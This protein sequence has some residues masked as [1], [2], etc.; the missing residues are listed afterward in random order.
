MAI[1]RAMNAVARRPPAADVY[2]SAA[3]RWPRRSGNRWSGDWVT[4]EEERFLRKPT[5]EP[6]RITRLPMPVQK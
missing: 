5:R 2:G 3:E 4:T 1:S 6:G